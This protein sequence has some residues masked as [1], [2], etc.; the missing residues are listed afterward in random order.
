MEESEI[1]A[2][3]IVETDVRREPRVVEMTQRHADGPVA[4][5]AAVNH[6]TAAVDAPAESAA[7]E[8]DAHDAEEQPED[9]ADEQNVEDGR[10]RLDQCV[11]H[12]LQ[13]N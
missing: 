7:E 3:N 1:C 13:A 4:D 10:D 8:T 2:E 5:D 6:L 9:E 11:Y 12:H